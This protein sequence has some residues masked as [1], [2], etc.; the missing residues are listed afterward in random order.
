[1]IAV[2]IVL[3][4]LSNS[5]ARREAPR[6]TYRG[7]AGSTI[8]IVSKFSSLSR[9]EEF[10]LTPKKSIASHVHESQLEANMAYCMGVIERRTR[11]I[12]TLLRS[13]LGGGRGRLSTRRRQASS[14]SRMLRVSYS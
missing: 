9:Y 8:D 7:K 3:R 4:G 5:T 6:E 2:V 1:V 11:P 14:Q 10:Q 13:D 12:G